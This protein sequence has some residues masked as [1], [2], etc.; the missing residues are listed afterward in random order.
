MEQK[1]KQSP[2]FVVGTA[3]FLFF[4]FF[5]LV[6]GFSGTKWTTCIKKPPQKLERMSALDAKCVPPRASN[7]HHLATGR[8]SDAFAA[9][10]SRSP[11]EPHLEAQ[12]EPGRPH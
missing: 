10:S 9:T 11:P 2:A 8:I 3:F 5:F 12:N 1:V 4:F 7:A 6:S